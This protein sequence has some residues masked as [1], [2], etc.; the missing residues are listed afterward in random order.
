MPT[1]HQTGYV[2]P[3]LLVTV[4][5]FSIVLY[6]LAQ[7]VANQYLLNQRQTA[8]EQAIAIAEAGINYYR[9]QLAHSPTDY[10]SNTS[11]NIDYIDP[12]GGTEGQYRIEVTPPQSGS[13]I[14]TIEST[15]W[16]TQ[17]PDIQRTIT[18][19]YGQPSFAQY[20]FLHDSN[21]WLG[22]GIEIFG[23]V[24]SNGGIRQDG[25]NH[26]IISSALDTYT[27]GSETGCSPAQNRPAVWGS[28]SDQGL[29][30]FP[31]TPVDFDALSVDFANMR[32]AAQSE[33]LYLNNSG[34]WGHHI[35]FNAN[36]TFNVYR[37][38][39]TRNRQGYD[40]DGGCQNLYQNIRTETS[41]GTYNQA[42][43]PIIF[44]E[45]TL[46]VEGTITSPIQVVAARF[47]IDTYDTNIW[48]YD[49]LI[50]SNLDGSIQAGVIAQNDII[51]YRDIPNNF[52]INAALLAKEGKVFRHLYNYCESSSAAIR[53]S[54]NIYGAII[55]AKKSYWNWNISGSLYSGFT[56][57]DVSYDANLLYSPPPYFPTTGE[58]EFIS[59]TE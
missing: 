28:G 16:S 3:A 19:Q 30:N 26:S 58:Y 9:W 39:Q 32:T 12:Q 36:G 25:I 24:H 53:N 42:D 18:V 27:C 55:S 35:V 56:N 52:T 7:L 31:Q 50:Y 22:D 43:Y 20:V 51:F 49:N 15:G 59:W 38:T 6:G 8:G 44:A 10:S 14:V 2:T 1:S 47:P 46:W 45:D 11:T 37:V 41:V 48:I 13:S 57:R 5:V 21:I 4:A 54:L 34:T 33:G 40:S 17:Y 29:W 23:P